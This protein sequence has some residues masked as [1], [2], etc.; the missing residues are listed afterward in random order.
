MKKTIKITITLL[1]VLAMIVPATVG[2]LA[3]SSQKVQPRW[4]SIFS[5]EL[6]MT[7]DGT[8]GN[9]TGLARKQ[10][11]AT[12]LEGIL[13]VYKI[14]NGNWIFVN[15]TSGRKPIGTLGLSVD[16]YSESGA[17]YIAVFEVTAYTGNAAETET[18]D[19]TKTCP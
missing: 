17:T 13:T 5:I 10:S 19:V 12:D 4:T 9:A 7:F 16:F 14:V 6:N 1:L 8:S 11:T 15:D 3:A 18:V 2:A